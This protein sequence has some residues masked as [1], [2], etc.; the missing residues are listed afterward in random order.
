MSDLNAPLRSGSRRRKSERRNGAGSQTDLPSGAG[1]E[2]SVRSRKKE[3][4]AK[5]YKH[6]RVYSYPLP[7]VKDAD[8]EVKR[9]PRDR[10]PARPVSPTEHKRSANDRD[11]P[12]CENQE[13]LARFR[14]LEFREV[15]GDPYRTHRNQQIAENCHVHGTLIHGSDKE[16]VSILLAH[17]CA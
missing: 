14:T 10:Q 12:H 8:P 3:Q 1:P 6:D 13:I 2:V 17:L 11:E 4:N 9:D 7:S 5:R 15:V 16:K